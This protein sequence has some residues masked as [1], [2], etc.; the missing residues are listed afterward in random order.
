MANRANQSQPQNSSPSSAPAAG[1][2]SS[3][4]APSP[5]AAPHPSLLRGFQSAPSNPHVARGGLAAKRRG[6]N[7]NL[8]DITGSDGMGVSGGGAS[9]AGLGV[10]LPQPQEDVPMR[11]NNLTASPFSN[12][13]K[14]VYVLSYYL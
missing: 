11:R 6:M 8:H 14:I 5:P 13:D 2:S 4:H 9:G 3:P 12:F 7:F 1:P 10:G